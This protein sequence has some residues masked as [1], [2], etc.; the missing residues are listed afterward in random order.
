MPATLY[1]DEEL[2]PLSGALRAQFREHFPDVGDAPGS[3][4]VA[5]DHDRLWRLATLAV[6]FGTID[7]RWTAGDP[8]TVLYPSEL[9]PEALRSAMGAIE[10]DAGRPLLIALDHPNW[11]FLAPWS[12]IS[13]CEHLWVAAPPDFSWV[14][15]HW[16]GEFVQFSR[17][18]F[19]HITQLAFVRRFPTPNGPLVEKP[20]YLIRYTTGDPWLVGPLTDPDERK[21][22]DR[23]FEFLSARSGRP[24]EQIDVL[25][26][27][28]VR[29][30]QRP[31]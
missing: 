22:Y 11:T 6:H 10:P 28:L 12:F 2:L 23:V 5:T 13:R 4:R 17:L 18:R 16:Y 29:K 31:R 7:D 26:D 1:D 30:T 3:I 25:P 20:Q 24:I 21:S 14:V 19:S 8:V 9:S 27:D 15:C